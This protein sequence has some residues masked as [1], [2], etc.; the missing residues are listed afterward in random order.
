MKVYVIAEAGVNHNGDIELAHKLV[1]EAVKSG[2]DAIKF[3]TFKAENLTSKKAKKANYQLQTTDNDESQLQ[4]LK[5]LELSKKDYID[6]KSYAENKKIDFITTAFDEESLDF[7]VND[8][9]VKKLK[10]PSGEITN[11]PFLLSH[12]RSNLDIILSTG[13]ANQHEIKKALDII[14][15]GYINPDIKVTNIDQFVDA[16]ENKDHIKILRDKVSILHCTTEY[17]APLEELNLSAIHT[18]EE[19]FGVRVGYS[20]HSE[21]IIASIVACSF[22]ASIIEKHFT[23]DRNMKGP[24]HKASLEP[25]ELKKMIEIIRKTGGMIGNGIKKPSLSETK[26]IEIVRKSIVT[27]KKITKGELF[28]EN[29]I[30]TKRPATGLSPMN[31]WDLLGKISKENYDEDEIIK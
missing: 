18:I 30:T 20:D 6:L 28:S 25:E 26:N 2:A 4:M 22:G 23:L 1:D 21:G 12:A 14:A 3:Q 27:K 11:G 29:N 17:P 7:I 31:Y 24:D 19:N 10:I 15:F 16:Y 13:M 5:K 8:L 9:K